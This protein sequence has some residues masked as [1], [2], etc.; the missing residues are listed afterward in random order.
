[1]PRSVVVS[2]GRSRYPFLLWRLAGLK[3]L[4]FQIGGCPNYGPFLD[5]YCS[6]EPNI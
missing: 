4:G 1:M 2:S 3:E 6:T 5:P